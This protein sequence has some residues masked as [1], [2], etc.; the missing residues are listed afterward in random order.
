MLDILIKDR[1]VELILLLIIPILLRN[2]KQVGKA[3]VINST[4]VVIV[5]L[6]IVK[7]ND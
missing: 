4:N 7:I 1:I 2:V 5:N 6:K 3:N